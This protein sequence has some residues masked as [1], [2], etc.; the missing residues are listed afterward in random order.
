MVLRLRL[1][2]VSGDMT[3]VSLPGHQWC[4]FVIDSKTRTPH[5][6]SMEPEGR[7]PTRLGRRSR[8]GSF[9][10]EDQRLGWITT[11]QLEEGLRP[12]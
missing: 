2:T 12:G 6:D 7:L 11:A 1:G 8:G 3:A 10:T 4:A 5:D 9:H